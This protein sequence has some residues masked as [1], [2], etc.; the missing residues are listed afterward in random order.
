MS[1][2]KQDTTY[3]TYKKVKEIKNDYAIIIKRTFILKD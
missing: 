2:I 3:K 1:S